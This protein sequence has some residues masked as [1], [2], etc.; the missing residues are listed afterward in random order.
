MKYIFSHF[1]FTFYFSCSV[2]SQGSIWYFG[3]GNGVDF[4]N[5]KTPKS[6]TNGILSRDNIS[7]VS[8]NTG[9]LSFYTDGMTVVN[10]QHK[11]IKNGSS[12]LGN[13]CNIIVPY[14]QKK[15]I[16]YI[17]SISIDDTQKSMFEKIDLDTS[18]MKRLT[19]EIWSQELARRDTVNQKRARLYYHL[20]DMNKNNG[21]GEVIVKNQLIYRCIK[22]DLVVAKHIN[23]K[24]FWLITHEFMNNR[25]RTYLIN[26]KGLDNNFVMSEIG[27]KSYTEY[28]GKFNQNGLRI[29]LDFNF[30]AFLEREVSTIQIFN[31]NNKT[32]EINKPISLK[33]KDLQYVRG[34][35]FS[36]D[37]SKL[38]ITFFNN[39]YY[40]TD[41]SAMIKRYDLKEKESDIVKSAKKK[42]YSK[43]NGTN[44]I[45]LAP[46]HK[47]YILSGWSVNCIENPNEDWENLQLY[48]NK[49]KYKQSTLSFF[50]NCTHLL[51]PFFS[52]I[53]IDELFSRQ[54]LFDT[55]QSKIE[56]WHAPILV[57][58]FQFLEDNKDTKITIIGHTDN[59]GNPK[60]NQKLSLER[61]KSIA[62]YFVNKKIDKNRIKV[63][64]LGHTKPI[65]NNDN[66][67]NKSKNRRVEF[68]IEKIK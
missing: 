41:H 60:E 52:P 46:D 35:E 39:N 55:K 51:P 47:I 3:N 48:F 12:L 6:I 59:E 8:D 16:Y 68:L 50:S 66:E 42:T 28:H 20:V 14:P 34:L 15:G 9:Q 26:E 62:D 31:F 1:I 33:D 25:F 18:K 4:I 7:V 54:I 29:S 63:E 10:H 40:H 58:I 56:S 27:L 64:S 19:P 30:L 13:A 61:A 2:F 24:D 57:D 21:L 17:F 49:F 32:G 43:V 67:E 5:K 23:G 38:Y 53:K 22:A 36:P 37:A 45:R 65:I 11:I 44:D